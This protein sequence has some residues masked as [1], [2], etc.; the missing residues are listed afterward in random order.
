MRNISPGT[1]T[2]DGILLRHLYLQYITGL[3]FWLDFDPGYCFSLYLYLHH[4]YSSFVFFNSVA[5]M[6]YF[7]AFSFSL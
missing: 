1:L 4:S 2:V 3:A 5:S 7:F 6:L